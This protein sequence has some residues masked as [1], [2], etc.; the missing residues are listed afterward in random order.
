MAMTIQLDVV[1]A[2]D[3]IFF[4]TSMAAGSWHRQR[5]VSARTARAAG[6]RAMGWSCKGAAA[7]ARY[8]G[9]RRGAAAYVVTA[10]WLAVANTMARGATRETSRCRCETTHRSSAHVLDEVAEPSGEH[11][12]GPGPPGQCVTCPRLLALLDLSHSLRAA[13]AAHSADPLSCCLLPLA[14]P[15]HARVVPLGTRPGRGAHPRC[16]A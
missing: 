6:G 9:Q 10:T 15:R 1:S 16:A 13:S 11:G 2:E 7:C 8:V 14:H 4:H 3:S 12:G 5:A